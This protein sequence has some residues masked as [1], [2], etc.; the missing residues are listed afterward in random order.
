[1]INNADRHDAKAE[2]EGKKWYAKML[3]RWSKGYVIILK[4]SIAVL[5]MCGH[6]AD[7]YMEIIGEM[8]YGFFKGSKPRC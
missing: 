5:A 3:M 7:T 1:M 6:L 4:Y 2:W 8:L